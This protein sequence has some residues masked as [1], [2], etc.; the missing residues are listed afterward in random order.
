MIATIDLSDAWKL[1]DRIARQ[2][3]HL[4]HF[5]VRSNLFGEKDLEF[6]PYTFV[7]INLLD[8]KLLKDLLVQNSISLIF[9][10][11]FSTSFEHP[12]FEHRSIIEYISKIGAIYIDCHYYASSYDEEV[13]L[14]QYERSLMP[15][16]GRN[17]WTLCLFDNETIESELLPEFRAGFRTESSRFKEVH[18]ELLFGKR[19]WASL[20]L[21]PPPESN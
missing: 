17:F 3:A 18:P 6:S 4:S 12:K 13:I 11:R 21:D 8:Q 10:L 14:E 1:N 15:L 9:D 19:R 16:K 20:C 2:D 5:D 7:H